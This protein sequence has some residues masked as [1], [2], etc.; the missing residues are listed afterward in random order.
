MKR[1]DECSCTVKAIIALFFIVTLAIYF[2]C[3]CSVQRVQYCKECS[4]FPISKLDSVCEANGVPTSLEDWPYSC[5]LRDSSVPVI[6][7]RSVEVLLDCSER[8]YTI[9]VSDS[10]FLF[11]D[12][13]SEAVKEVCYDW[14]DSIK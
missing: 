12:M 5:V 6:R 14:V 7:Y 4:R 8:I 11:T 1:N 13:M 3:S 9:E 10:T 2:L